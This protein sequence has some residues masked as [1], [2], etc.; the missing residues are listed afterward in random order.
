MLW[1]RV[2]PLRPGERRFVGL[3]RLPRLEGGTRFPPT[4]RG[5]SS[6]DRRTRR[7]AESGRIWSQA[8]SAMVN[9]RSSA[10]D[11]YAGQK[12]EPS[13]GV[14]RSQALSALRVYSRGRRFKSCPRY[15]FQARILRVPRLKGSWDLITCPQRVQKPCPEATQRADLRNGYRLG[16]VDADSRGSANAPTWHGQHRPNP[17]R[18]R[19]ADLYRGTLRVPQR[20]HADSPGLAPCR[21]R[22]TCGSRR[23]ATALLRCRRSGVA[24]VSARGRHGTLSRGAVT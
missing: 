11:V 7:W 9:Q 14:R 12:L 10:S 22:S 5:P 15:E 24:P 6:H 3:I 2:A 1:T 4:R 18:P 16:P 13:N 17:Q 8:E 20:P 23:S 21:S 19:A